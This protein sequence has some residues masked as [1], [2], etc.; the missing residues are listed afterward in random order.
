AACLAL[1]AWFR[2]FA[3]VR[4]AFIESAC[5]AALVLGALAPRRLGFLVRLYAFAGGGV[6]LALSGHALPAGFLLLAGA[7]GASVATPRLLTA[8]AAAAAALL[9]L[10]A[11]A[12]VRAGRADDLRLG[13][14]DTTILTHEH[15]QVW[16][17]VAEVVPADGLV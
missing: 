9:A 3:G 2:D 7:A 13:T 1:G 5:V 12:A 16:H 14:Y 8:T 17:E 6:L 10:G 15:Y 4:A 11:A